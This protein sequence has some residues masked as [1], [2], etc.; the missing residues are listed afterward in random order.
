MQPPYSIRFSHDLNLLDIRWHRLFDEDSAAVYATDVRHAFVRS[1]FRA[2]Y[3]LRMDMS[4]SSVQ[5][6]RA[7]AII[8]ERLAG[9]PAA[10]RIAIV[11]TSNVTRLQIRRLMTQP[12]L[13]IF[14]DAD[15]ALAW[16]LEG[17]DAGAT[18]RLH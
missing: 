5:P 2:G 3:R 6:Q 12:Y 1:G 4:E 18:A 15:D 10:E 14:A 16:L 7:I 8:H 9:F 17:D 11:A 13:R